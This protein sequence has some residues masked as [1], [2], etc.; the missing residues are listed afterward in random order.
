MRGR[1][2]IHL[3]RREKPDGQLEQW[4]VRITAYEA[5]ETGLTRPSHPAVRSV[6]S[7]NMKESSS[8]WFS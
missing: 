3:C 5:E 6:E 7:P 1:K 4:A 2:E 8:S